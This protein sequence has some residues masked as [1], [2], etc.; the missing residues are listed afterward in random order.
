MELKPPAFPACRCPPF[1]TRHPVHSKHLVH[2]VQFG[3][4]TCPLCPC[5]PCSTCPPCAC[6]PCPPYACPSCPLCLPCLPCTCP[7]TCTCTCPPTCNCT[8]PPTCTCTCPPNPLCPFPPTTLSTLCLSSVRIS[9]LISLHP[10]LFEN[11]THIW[12]LLYFVF[13]GLVDI[14]GCEMSGRW[15]GDGRCHQLS[16]NIWLDRLTWVLR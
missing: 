1:P 11:I 14:D 3:L 10:L 4:V 5:K 15:V 8:C 12:S 16:R 2:L 9:Y 6:P 7:P 13:V